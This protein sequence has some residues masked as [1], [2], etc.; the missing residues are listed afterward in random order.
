MKENVIWKND[1]LRNYN[2]WKMSLKETGLKK[3]TIKKGL[4]KV[5]S[6]RKGLERKKSLWETKAEKNI[7]MEDQE[8]KEMLD[9]KKKAKSKR[10]KLELYQE[11][12]KK[13]FLLREAFNIKKTV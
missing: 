7:E 2:E 12:R 8:L 6:E 9:S 10:K 13:L 1:D 3:K 5:F 4:F 11:C